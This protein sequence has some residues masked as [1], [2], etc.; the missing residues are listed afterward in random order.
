MEN[1]PGPIAARTIAAYNGMAEAYLAETLDRDLQADYD[2]FF[3]HLIGPGPFDLLDLGCGPGRDLRYFAQRGH[4]PVGVDGAARMVA[5]AR[6]YSGCRVLC[7]DLRALRLPREKFDG[8]FASASLFHLQPEE[9]PAVLQSVRAALRP[10]GVFLTLNPRGHD[11][12]GFHGERF[13]VYYGL[14]SWRKLLR[15]AGFVELAHRYRPRGVAR[16]KQNW[17]TT[18]WRKPA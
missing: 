7:Q 5:V 4:R 10:G 14:A 17:L 6:A 11:E 18:L 2:L 3:G 1:E 12:R 13:C 9:L 8:A 15:A 16:A